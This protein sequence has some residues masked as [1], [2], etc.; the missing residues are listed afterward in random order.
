MLQCIKATLAKVKEY[1]LYNCILLKLP[2]RDYGK[3]I[4][5]YEIM[6][7]TKLSLSNVK[8]VLSRAEL[9]NIM[10]GSSGPGGGGTGGGSGGCIPRGQGYC[11]SQGPYCCSGLYC[12]TLTGTC[13][14]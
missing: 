13:V 4:N 12:Y 1:A 3:K 6:K 8:N 14:A 2:E 9:K 10:A 5:F 11:S 7:I